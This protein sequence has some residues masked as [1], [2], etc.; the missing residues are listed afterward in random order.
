MFLYKKENLIRGQIV[1]RPSKKCKTPYVG[2]VKLFNQ[3]KTF[4][5]SFKSI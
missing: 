1:K 5:E 4:Q 3:N 2:D